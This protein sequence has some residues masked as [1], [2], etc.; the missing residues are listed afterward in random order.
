MSALIKESQADI[1]TLS[2]LGGFSKKSLPQGNSPSPDTRSA[3]AL[4]LVSASRTLLIMLISY[5]MCFP[6]GVGEDAVKKEP[7]YTVGGDVD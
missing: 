1:F 5:L 3:G 4:V 6:T 7:S 2:A